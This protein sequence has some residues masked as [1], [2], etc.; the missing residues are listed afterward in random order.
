MWFIVGG[1][2][3]RLTKETETE[4]GGKEF[5]GYDL[6]RMLSALWQTTLS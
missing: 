4:R 6:A 1:C 5:K 2:I 3:K